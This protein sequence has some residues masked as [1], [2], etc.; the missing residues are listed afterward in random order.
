MPDVSKRRRRPNG[1]FDN[2]DRVQKPSAGITDMPYGDDTAEGPQTF[3]E[4]M[5]FESD[6]T[7]ECDQEN[8]LYSTPVT[9]DDVDD[10]ADARN[11]AQLRRTVDSLRDVKLDRPVVRLTEDAYGNAGKPEVSEHPDVGHLMDSQSE[12]ASDRRE[13]WATDGRGEL[14]HR[15]GSA[16]DSD[17]DEA[18]PS[19]YRELNPGVSVARAKNMGADELV[20]NSSPLNLGEKFRERDAE[21]FEQAPGFE[22]KSYALGY[23]END[24]DVYEQMAEERGL[25]DNEWITRERLLG[26]SAYSHVNNDYEPSEDDIQ[27]A[28]WQLTNSMREHG[29][30]VG[31]RDAERGLRAAATGLAKVEHDPTIRFQISDGKPLAA[32]R[33]DWNNNL[34]VEGEPSAHDWP[35][36]VG[37]ENEDDV[38]GLM[39]EE[40]G[41][42]D[43]RY[44]SGE[45]LLGLSAYSHI[46]NGHEPSEDDIHDAERRLDGLMREQDLRVGGRN[47]SSGLRSATIG[48]VKVEHDPMIRTKVQD[49]KPLDDARR[50]WNAP[51]VQ[52]GFSAA[53][54]A[55]SGVRNMHSYSRERTAEYI[56]NNRDRLSDVS[57]LSGQQLKALSMY[58]YADSAK[59]DREDVKS[60]MGD[61]YRASRANGLYVTGGNAHQGLKSAAEGLAKLRSNPRLSVRDDTYA[62]D[63]ANAD[64]GEAATLQTA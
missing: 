11:A 36:V 25:Q 50:D 3:E 15:V 63:S 57:N 58:A 30:Y 2:E 32:A 21:L 61:L 48:L 38:Y 24:D 18:S 1:E 53:P 51:T 13:E 49:S 62:W 52:T 14:A 29:L 8:V 10:E 42:R 43:N 33:N 27:N 19:V 6:R 23:G 34:M 28:A 45:R 5:D 47:A 54:H 60:A 16:D 46:D 26:L 64:W 31:G 4:L 12:N 35:T 7:L 9:P 39:A 17:A 56:Q 55:I 59:P 40:T 37:G 22:A 44:L 20:R 41:L